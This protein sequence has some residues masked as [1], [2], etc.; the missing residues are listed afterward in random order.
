MARTINL[1]FTEEAAP[2]QFRQALGYL[3]SWA[4]DAY[5][6]VNIFPDGLHDLIAVYT[7]TG[8]ESKYVIGAIFDKQ[9]GKYSF[10]S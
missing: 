3:T 4:L 9:T 6:E 8:T 5:D 1:N 7:R 10:H 2:P